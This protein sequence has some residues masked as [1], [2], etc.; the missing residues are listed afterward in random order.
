MPFSDLSNV[1]PLRRRLRLRLTASSS[2][3]GCESR[4]ISCGS[5]ETEASSTGS[6]ILIYRRASSA[7]VQPAGPCEPRP[8]RALVVALVD[9]TGRLRHV[10]CTCAFFDVEGTCTHIWE[11]SFE[12]ASE[13]RR[14]PK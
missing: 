13:G 8:S 14:A 6:I 7:A 9:R 5:R 1:I 12:L 4:A 2:R 10:A 11:A 3:T